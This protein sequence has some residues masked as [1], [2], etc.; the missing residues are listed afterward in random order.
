MLNWGLTAAALLLFVYAVRTVFLSSKG[1]GDG[2][3]QKLGCGFALVAA[4]LW[5]WVLNRY[6]EDPWRAIRLGLGV[7]LVLPAVQAIAKPGGASILRAATG[8]VLGVVIAGPVVQDLWAEYG[9]DTRPKEQR[10]LAEKLDEL[11][12]LRVTLRDRRDALSELRA[13]VKADIKASGKSWE[14]IQA[15]PEWLKRLEVLRRIDEEAGK[16]EAR[17]VQI[18]ARLPE[19]RAALAAAEAGRPEEPSV[20]SELDALLRALEAAPPLDELSIVEQH[21]R[22][23]ELQALFEEEF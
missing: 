21:A 20:D 15:S 6:L 4:A 5:I 10:T 23:Q 7:L 14:E 22:K 9:I 17:L 18:D 3:R 11:E 2:G 19:L 13:S 12:D 8:L 1:E 16:A